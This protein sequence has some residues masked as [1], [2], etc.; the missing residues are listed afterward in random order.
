MV[1]ALVSTINFCAS[2]Q[3]VPLKV[4]SYNVLKGL[5][6]DSLNM[7]RFVSWV[8]GKSPDVIFYQEM[9]GFTQHSLELFAGRYE[10]PYAVIAKETGYSVAITS[11]YPIVDVHKVLDNMWHGYIYAS[12]HGVSVFAVHLSPFVYKK[13]LS[14]IRQVLAHAAMLPKSTPV[15][16]AGDF[17][18]YQAGD[19][20]NY[21]QKALAAQVKREAGNAEM[22]NLNKGKFD[23]SVTSELEL[24]GYRDA[25]NLFS[26]AFNYT[27]PTKKYD[28][29][30]KS[31]I[32]ID[33]I[34]MNGVLQRRAG[35][36]SVIYDQ[37]TDEMSDHYPIWLTLKP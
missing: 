17:N 13:R 4:L 20:V 24:H 10:H 14:E 26:K 27:M 21:T 15:M 1:G 22:R 8:K 9:N 36:A 6:S 2:A 18:S 34:W 29:A 33:Y 25:V 30:F 19:S 28:A 7:N 16:I 5:Q 23:Y 11:R 32:R 35:G 37:H 12:V 3:K 31:K